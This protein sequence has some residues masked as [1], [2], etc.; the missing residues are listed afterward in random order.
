VLVRQD[1]GRGSRRIIVYNKPAEDRELV[2]RN[3]PSEQIKDTGQPGL[4]AW[5][6]FCNP[7]C[8]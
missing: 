8:H 2:E 1:V 7:F 3:K 5:R 4:E 6:R